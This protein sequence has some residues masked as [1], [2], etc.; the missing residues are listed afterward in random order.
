MTHEE[1]SAKVDSMK[2][3]KICHRTPVLGIHKSAWQIMCPKHTDNSIPFSITD[4][5]TLNGTI[6][7]NAIDCWNTLNNVIESKHKENNKC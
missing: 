5:I 1:L 2:K 7:S 6:I 4:N 3:C